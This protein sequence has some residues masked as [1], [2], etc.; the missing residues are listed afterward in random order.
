VSSFKGANNC[1]VKLFENI[2]FTGNTVGPASSMTYV[3]DA[4]NDKAS[5]IHLS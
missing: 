4:M 1:Q 5:S 2:N 3:G